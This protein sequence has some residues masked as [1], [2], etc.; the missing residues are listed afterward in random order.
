M[1]VLAASCLA[2]VRCQRIEDHRLL[3]LPRL[4]TQAL[5]RRLVPCGRRRCNVVAKPEKAD[6]IAHFTQHCAL[7]AAATAGFVVASVDP[8]LNDPVKLR[9][10]LAETNCKM[11]IYDEPD[12][13]VI[14]NAIPEFAMFD[15][16]RSKPFSVSLSGIPVSLL[17]FRRRPPACR[18]SSTLSQFHWTNTKVLPIL[19]SRRDHCSLFSVVQLSTF[20]GLPSSAKRCCYHIGRRAAL[21][22]L[23]LE[24][25]EESVHARSS[26][27]HVRMITP[28]HQLTALYSLP[29]GPMLS[30]RSL[31]LW[32]RSC[33]SSNSYHSAIQASW[34]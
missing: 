13:G 12:L 31:L 16:K 3:L 10:I 32:I 29:S 8:T 14:E 19:S 25:N 21:C 4:G 15:A 22:R 6:P 26:P 20:V 9:Q 24:W 5:R 2:I 18:S 28:R 27:C 33:R 30:P 17:R 1:K 34:A 11:L 23:C 7:F